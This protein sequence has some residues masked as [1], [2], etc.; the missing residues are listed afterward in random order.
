MVEK[1]CVHDMYVA[2]LEAAELTLTNLKHSDGAPPEMIRE[3]AVRVKRLEL[4]LAA[5]RVGQAEYYLD[6]LKCRIDFLEARAASKD[7][8][9]KTEIEE[10]EW[11]RQALPPNTATVNALSNQVEDLKRQIEELISEDLVAAR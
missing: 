8:A 2:D 1:R 5:A 10:L 3:A 11:A 7:G 6:T 4:K 9:T